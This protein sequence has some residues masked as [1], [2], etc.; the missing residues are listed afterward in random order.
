MYLF[1]YISPYL[2]LIHRVNCCRIFGATI[3]S[4]IFSSATLAQTK[5]NKNQ[6]VQKAPDVNIKNVQDSVQYA[7]GVYMAEYLLRGG[8]TTLDLNY[9]LAGLNDRY[10]NNP[11]KISDSLVYSLIADY[12]TNFQLQ[13]SKALEKELFEL[14]KDKPG[15]GKLPS[16]VQYTIINPSKGPKPNETDSV[17]IHYK[18]TLPDGRVFENTF[19]S[20]QPV[21]TTPG[22]L[23]PGLNEVLQ[24]MPVGSRW[25][26]FIPASLAYGEKGN[27]QIPPNSALLILVELIQILG[28]K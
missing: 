2:F 28:K 11:R 12:Q 18:G 23:I 8:F 3:F 21:K 13:K 19:V 9:F 24:L 10:K 26:V 6:A 22:T 20:N 17:L 7:L 5:N 14:L 25:Q 27:N 4:I 16:G 15:V 1:S